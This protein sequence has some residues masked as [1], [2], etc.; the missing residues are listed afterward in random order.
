MSI[1]LFLIDHSYHGS[2]LNA[3]FPPIFIQKY[4]IWKCILFNLKYIHLFSPWLSNFLKAYI[5]KFQGNMFSFRE[6]ME[7]IEELL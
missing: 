2:E 7:S 3:R 1:C 6:Q 4:Y 5:P